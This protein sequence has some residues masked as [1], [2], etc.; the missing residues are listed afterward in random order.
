MGSAGDGCWL[1]LTPFSKWQAEA[2]I[3]AR[4][5]FPAHR[6]TVSVA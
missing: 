6:E 2:G 5:I 4:G 3:M 1:V